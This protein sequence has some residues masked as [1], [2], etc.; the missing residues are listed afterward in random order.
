MTCFRVAIFY[1]NEPELAKKNPTPTSRGWGGLGSNKQ[2]PEDD[3]DRGGQGE[4]FPS[5]EPARFLK[6][7]RQLVQF[8]DRLLLS[9]RLGEGILSPKWPS[10]KLLGW[11]AGGGGVIEIHLRLTCRNWGGGN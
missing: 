5:P 10:S 4:P 9:A 8:H 6:V 3:E 7:G 1:Q 11:E 2:D